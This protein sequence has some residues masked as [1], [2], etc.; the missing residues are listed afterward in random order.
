MSI[1]FNI[2]DTHH[3]T[4]HIDGDWVVWRC[5]HCLGYERRLNLLT[6]KMA[7][8]GKT[9]FQHQGSNDGKSNI[10]HP[11]TKNLSEN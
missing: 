3:C 10:S 11:L 5:P 6:G 1:E 7:V 8:K 2:Q 9:D 4:S